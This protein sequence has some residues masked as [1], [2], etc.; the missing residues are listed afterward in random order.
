MLSQVCRRATAQEQLVALFSGDA[1]T[2]AEVTYAFV[3][4]LD[5]DAVG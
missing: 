5:A 1:D 4:C 3:E 2:L